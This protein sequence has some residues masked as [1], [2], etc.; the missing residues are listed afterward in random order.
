MVGICEYFVNDVGG[1][2]RRDGREK[3]RSPTMYVQSAG[4]PGRWNLYR[5]RANGEV[6]Y[7]GSLRRGGQKYPV[8]HDC[9]F[10]FLLRL[11]NRIIKVYE[12]L[13]PFRVKNSIEVV[14]GCK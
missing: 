4:S 7:C 8:Q 14:V 9:K 13:Y 10:M 12:C 1:V 3:T 11:F 2:R 5:F 6:F